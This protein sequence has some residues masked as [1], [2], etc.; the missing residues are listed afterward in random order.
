LRLLSRY[1]CRQYHHHHH[2]HHH[3]PSVYRY[4]DI[5]DISCSNASECFCIGVWGLGFGVWGLGFGVWG[6]G[7]RRC[8]VHKFDADAPWPSFAPAPTAHLHHASSHM[9]HIP[10][11]RH[12]SHVTHPHHMSHVTR[13]TSHIPITRH[14]H[15][16]SQDAAL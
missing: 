11:T 6:L 10:I 16:P 7:S 15:R 3:L 8:V 4:V 9:S 13:H 14:L 1:R 12:T 2:H 5:I